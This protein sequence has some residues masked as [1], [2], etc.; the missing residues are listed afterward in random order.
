[1]AETALHG[2]RE[3]R[4]H[5]DWRAGVYAGLIA[6]AVFL[7]LEMGMVWLF[8]GESPWAPPRMIAA[9]VLGEGVLP[10][11]PEKPA[12]FSLGILAT[13]MVIHFLLSIIYG[14]VGAAIVANR[15]GYGGAIVVGGLCGF[16]IYLVNFYPIAAA[17]FPWFAMARNWISIFAHVVFGAVVGAAYAGF[18]AANARSRSAG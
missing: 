3:E 11:P 12:T 18:R 14:L 17:F 13:A 10:M 7:I 1:M 8:R 5:I 15:M 16:A 2:G 4:R 6:G 9:M